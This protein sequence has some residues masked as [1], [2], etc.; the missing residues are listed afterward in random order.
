MAKFVAMISETKAES[1]QG[2]TAVRSTQPRTS[3]RRTNRSGSEALMHVDCGV[4]QTFVL[5]SSRHR[6][7]TEKAALESIPAASLARIVSSP[8]TPS[9]QLERITRIRRIRRIS[10]NCR[11]SVRICQAATEK[12]SRELLFDFLCPLSLAAQRPL[13]F[14]PVHSHSKHFFLFRCLTF[15]PLEGVDCA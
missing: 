8:S 13:R 7:N 9:V 1:I 12:L 15:P 4:S 2:S 14:F 3:L 6:R 10:G 11:R 5:S